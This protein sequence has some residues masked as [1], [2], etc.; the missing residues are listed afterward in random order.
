MPAPHSEDNNRC[1]HIRTQQD[2]LAN[3]SG[4][5]SPHLASHSWANASSCLASLLSL[6][7]FS[8]AL[9]SLD[10]APEREQKRMPTSKE[11]QA[12]P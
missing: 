2:T 10:L 8:V 5:G 6:I 3:L 7:S 4:D 11:G 9:R 1:S 12:A